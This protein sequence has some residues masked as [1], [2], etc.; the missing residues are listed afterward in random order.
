MRCKLKLT[1]LCGGGG[2]ENH[3]FNT[4]KGHFAATGHLVFRTGVAKPQRG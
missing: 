4:A 1:W 3:V 2:G